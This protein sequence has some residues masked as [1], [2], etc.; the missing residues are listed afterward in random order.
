MHFARAG[1]LILETI[2]AL[3]S[4]PLPPVRPALANMFIV[5][6]ARTAYNLARLVR[7][8]G[9]GSRARAMIGIV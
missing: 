8:A 7:P 6:Y 2:N 5:Y 9:A 1:V 3:Q 4:L